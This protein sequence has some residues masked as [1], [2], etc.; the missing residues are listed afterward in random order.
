MSR[1]SRVCLTITSGRVVRIAAAIAMA[2]VASKAQADVTISDF[3]NF[4]PSGQYVNWLPAG[5]TSGPTDWRVVANNSGGAFYTIPGGVHATNENLLEVNFDVNPNDAAHVFNVVLIDGDGTERVFRY[6]NLPVGNDQT[7]SRSLLVQDEA[8]GW[9]QDNNPGSTAGLDITNITTF[10]MQGSFANSL[11]TDL[12]FDNLALRGVIPEPAT[13]AL[14]GLGIVGGM[15]ILRR[16][17][18]G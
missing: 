13:A 11:A 1:I 15:A 3:S 5:F 7:L 2:V 10:H 8:T 6:G 12:T 17:R 14:L 16:R 18:E 9:L 4:V